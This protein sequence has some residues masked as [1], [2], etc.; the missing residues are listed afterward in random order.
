MGLIATLQA[1]GL[2]C[3]VRVKEGFSSAV[4]SGATF[5]SIVRRLDILGVV[6][7][8]AFS[9]LAVLATFYIS[10]YSWRTGE[11]PGG[12]EWIE[13]RVGLVGL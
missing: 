10:A 3:R 1:A 7:S 13:G 9:Q 5:N 11:Q 4:R 12:C 8:V 2:K 6:T